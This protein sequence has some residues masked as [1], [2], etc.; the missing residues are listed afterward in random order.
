MNEEI[1]KYCP[2]VK[3]GQLQKAIPHCKFR[4]RQ[5]VGIDDENRCCYWTRKGLIEYCNEN[6]IQI[7]M[8]TSFSCILER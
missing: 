7:R 2:R 1:L 5:F 6:D 3:N 4:G 8:G